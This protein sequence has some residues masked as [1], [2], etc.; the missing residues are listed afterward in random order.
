MAAFGDTGQHT[1]AN[2]PVQLRMADGQRGDLGSARLFWTVNRRIV[3]FFLADSV[4]RGRRAATV[5]PLTLERLMTSGYP[6]RY[7]SMEVGPV[8]PG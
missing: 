2:C 1:D 6:V 8:W 3:Q 4:R 7:L 5:L